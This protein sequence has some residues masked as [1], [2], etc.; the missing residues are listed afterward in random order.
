VL[1]RERFREAGGHIAVTNSQLLGLL[2]ANVDAYGEQ[3]FLL[4]GYYVCGHTCEH[5]E[6][7]THAA[8]PAERPS[9]WAGP[10][11]AKKFT[12]FLGRHLI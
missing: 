2:P 8:P 4:G 3:G 6:E 11:A 9:R 12:T 1:L 7:Q 5:D 10:A